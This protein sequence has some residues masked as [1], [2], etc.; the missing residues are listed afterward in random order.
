VSKSFLKWY[1]T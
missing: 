1:A